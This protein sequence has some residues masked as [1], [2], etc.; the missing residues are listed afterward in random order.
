MKPMAASSAMMPLPK[1][2]PETFGPTISR[3]LNLAPANSR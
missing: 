2:S 1:S 3:G